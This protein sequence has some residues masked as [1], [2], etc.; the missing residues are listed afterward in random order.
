MTSSKQPNDVIKT[1]LKI[2]VYAIKTK[3]FELNHISLKANIIKGT[4]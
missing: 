4:K 1:G 3:R 2:I